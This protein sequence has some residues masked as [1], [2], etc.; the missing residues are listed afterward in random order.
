MKRIL[1]LLA[2]LY[3]SA[4]RNRYGAEYEAL[5][6]DAT[7]RPQDTFN[8]LWGAI[9]MQLTSRRFVRIVLSCTL[10]G[11][12]AAL[13]ISFAVPP[14][15]SSQ[16]GIIVDQDDNASPRSALEVLGSNVFSRE[17]L[18]SIIQKENL[19]PHERANATSNAIDKMQQSI[20]I[21]PGNYSQSNAASGV[22]LTHK[23]FVIQFDYSDPHIAQRVNGELVSR[24]IQQALFASERSATA[25]GPQFHA[26]FRVA[27]EPTLPQ[28][29]TGL[30][31]IQLGAIGLFT[32]LLGSL[33][34]AA[35][36]RSR[37]NAVA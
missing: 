32:G 22:F 13:A 7:P 2:R 25:G 9:K 14:D 17:F 3:P 36:L 37:R 19:Y 35:V 28:K 20:H 34:L 15:Y 16:T 10:A 26:R 21:V 6:D 18:A 23:F 5:L 4:W 24:F 1:K 11:I 29:P 27:N 33:I 12:L 31:R 8:V 30:S